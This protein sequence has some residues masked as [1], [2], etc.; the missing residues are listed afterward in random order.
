MTT[1]PIRTEPPTRPT[2]DTVNLRKS[3]PSSA[4]A[5]PLS[6]WA[7]LRAAPWRFVAGSWAWR[8]LAYLMVSVLFGWITVALFTSI[9]L[10]P[11]VPVWS[12]FL[13]KAERA[14]VKLLGVEAIANPHPALPSMPLSARMGE[15][16][17]E[18]A[19]WRA[20]AYAV[21]LTVMAPT[22]SG[23]A[24]LYAAVVFTMLIAP[25]LTRTDD[26]WVGP[27]LIDTV[28]EGVIL[29]IAAIPLLVLGLYVCG[30]CACALGAIARSLLGAN[31]ERLSAEVAGL[32][33]SRGILVDSFADQRRRIEQDLHDGPQRDLVAASIQLGELALATDDEDLRKQAAAAQTQVESAMARL[34]D[35]VRGVH[36]RVLDDHG[37]PAACMEL[38]GALP[39]RVVLGTGWTTDTRL[40]DDV[41]QAM[42]YTASEAVT[43]AVK[44]A[45]AAGVT[46]TFQRTGGTGGTEQMTVE[47]DGKGGAT[48]ISGR[49][50][51][52]LT[53]RAAAVGA[54][55][56]VES[57]ADGGTR[58]T[59]R[60]G[61]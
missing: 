28:G 5:T 51:A 32:Q 56:G 11:T 22:I 60:R 52:G 14:R 40:G 41:E 45:D 8:A 9:L 49:G 17:G 15:R 23:I 21:V 19:T 54:E 24:L 48:M 39:V 61:Q 2:R 6:S 37:V 3:P 53:E 7:H 33:A 29:T 31:E 35:T 43:N 42:Y 4:V 38:V 12:Y 57:P 30:V 50:L 36:P 18:S 20:T 25:T 27:W 1:N 13:A 26:V 58:I 44:H 55:L 59:W 16:M 34:R 47:D 10:I 46:I